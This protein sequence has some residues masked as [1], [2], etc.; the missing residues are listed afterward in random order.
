MYNLSFQ[1][2]SMGWGEKDNSKKCKR[3]AGIFYISF[4]LQIEGNHVNSSHIR[5]SRLTHIPLRING[6][7]VLA[8]LSDFV[9]C[10]AGGSIGGRFGPPILPAYEICKLNL[11]LLSIQK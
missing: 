6:F 1:V 5:G 8:Q 11:K 3:L 10:R 4:T 2:D 7:L 9:K